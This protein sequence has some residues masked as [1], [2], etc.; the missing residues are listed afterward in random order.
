MPD[1]N[2]R[3]VRI[4]QIRRAQE[5]AREAQERTAAAL[6]PEKASQALQDIQFKDMCFEFQLDIA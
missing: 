1:P 2:E 3:F 6:D 4:K 5:E